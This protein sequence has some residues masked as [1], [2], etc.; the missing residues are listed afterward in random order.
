MKSCMMRQ[1]QLYA[2]FYAARSAY[3][4]LVPTRASP[5]RRTAAQTARLSGRYES[6]PSSTLGGAGWC[7]QQGNIAGAPV[8]KLVAVQRTEQRTLGHPAGHDLARHA[9]PHFSLADADR[10]PAC[11]AR[12]TEAS[13]RT[14]S[15]GRLRRARKCDDARPRRWV[16][17][18]CRRRVR[19]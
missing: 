14:A 15:A 2:A 16:C 13:R 9:H 3:T 7:G 17:R 8:V 11:T 12:E 6:C 18:V 4:A 1:Q 19:R 10:A 5:S